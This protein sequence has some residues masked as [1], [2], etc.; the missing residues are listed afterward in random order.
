MSELTYLTDV[1]MIHCVVNSNSDAT[2]KM[3]LAARGAGARFAM[4]HNARGYGARERLGALG[5]AVETEKDAISVLVSTEQR[6]IVLEAM[7]KAGELDRA[8]AGIIY[9]TPIE[10]LASFVP[11][12]VI[13]KLKQAG[14]WSE[15]R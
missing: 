13:K 8:G 10:K 11:D 4:G 9:V 1:W 15:P 7:F 5:V 6:D 12:S 3:L 14:K 2:E